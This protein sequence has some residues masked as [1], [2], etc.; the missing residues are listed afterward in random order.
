MQIAGACPI[1][2]LAL[3]GGAGAAL[4]KF[5]GAVDEL[6]SA[7]GDRYADYYAA[8]IPAASRQVPWPDY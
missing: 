5:A 6:R 1:P 3:Y 4:L 8:A 2:A 7:A